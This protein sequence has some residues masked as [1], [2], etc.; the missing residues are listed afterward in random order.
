[1][2]RIVEILK[3]SSKESI[4]FFSYS[5]EKSLIRAQ[6]ILIDLGHKTLNYLE[7]EDVMINEL[8]WQI[9][10]ALIRR[11]EFLLAHIGFDSNEK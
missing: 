2:E 8:C 4:I 11:G 3:T 7:E 9:L 10:I 5:S 1:M 6:K